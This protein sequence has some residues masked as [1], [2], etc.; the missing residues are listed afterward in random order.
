MLTKKKDKMAFIQVADLDDE[1]EVVVFPK[2]YEMFKD[3]IIKDTPLIFQGKVN[4]KNKDEDPNTEKK[5]RDDGS[6]AKSYGNK[7]IILDEIKGI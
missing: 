5:V 1:I 4:L 2:A 7:A 6:E 3:K